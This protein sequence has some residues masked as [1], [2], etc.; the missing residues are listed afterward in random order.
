MN[1]L[2]TCAASACVILAACSSGG[3]DTETR[4]VTIN[5]AAEANNIA[6]D[7]DTQLS[8]LGTQNSNASINDF[9][10]YVHD[11]ALLDAA[12]NRY[13]LSLAQDTWQQSNVALLDFTNKD[14]TCTGA[15]KDTRTL[16]E[17]S[18]T[19]PTGRV[20]TGV[21]FKLGVPASLNHE[22]RAIATAPLDI[23][24]LH[25]NWQNGYKFARLDVAPAGGITR[26]SDAGFNAT[27]W[28]FHLGST[29][30]SG[31]PQ[32]NE[33][34]TC[35]RPNRPAIRLTNFDSEQDQ[36]LLD[37]GQ[38]IA[39]QNLTEDQGGAPGCMSASTD[40]ECAGVFTALGMDVS[41]GETDPALTQTVFSVQ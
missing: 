17:G 4:S 8:G 41:T 21:E 1:I 33:T 19:L 28:N 27:S 16:V 10:F 36:I 31:D 37:Y 35:A 20:L 11:V 13:A 40:A 15:A 22:D 23:T 7:C 25:W 26:P 24:G 39:T 6:V 34:V 18:V 30:C 29:N 12:G 3:D 38:L 5:F 9:R 32:L 2:K 14:T